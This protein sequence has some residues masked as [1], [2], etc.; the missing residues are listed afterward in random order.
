MLNQLFPTQ[1]GETIEVLL[2][3]GLSRLV[4]RANSHSNVFIVIRRRVGLEKV[5]ARFVNPSHEETH[6]KGP[7]RRVTGFDLTFLSYFIDESLSGVVASVSVPIVEALV[8]HE[9]AQVPPIS[10]QACYRN[11]RFGVDIEHFLLVSS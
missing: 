11:A 1:R 3:V 6:S 8:P 4:P 10:C 2:Q 9:F 5:G 7:L